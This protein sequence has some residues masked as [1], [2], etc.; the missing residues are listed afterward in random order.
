MTPYLH[1][2]NI[3][4]E[5]TDIMKGDNLIMIIGVFVDGNNSIMNEFFQL[6]ISTTKISYYLYD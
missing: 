2:E 1:K 3:K 6:V 5:V 4:L